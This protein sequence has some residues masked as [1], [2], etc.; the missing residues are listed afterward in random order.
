MNVGIALLPLLFLAFLIVGIL[1]GLVLLM[2][3]PKARVVT[4]TLLGSL[5]LIAM[6]L[7]AGLFFFRFY[8]TAVQRSATVAQ[9]APTI[10]HQIGT[11]SFAIST[12]KSEEEI[13]QEM[14]AKAAG[15]VQA[16]VRAV[17][18][19]LTEAEPVQA[20]EKDTAESLPSPAGRGTGGEGGKDAKDA[21]QPALTL[22][23]S[24]RE[25]GPARATLSQ[26]ERGPATDRPAWIDAPPQVV[27]DAYQMSISV[28]PY[29]TRVECNE[30]L[31]EALQ[32]ALDQYAEVCLGDQTVDRVRLPVE[33]LRKEIVKE[34]WEETRQHSVGPMVWLHVLLKF[35][36]KLKDQ[37]LEAYGRATVNRR[38]QLVGAWA[39][40]GLGLLTV[41]F[42]YLKIDMATG[43]AYRGRLRL[44]AVAVIL[45]VIAA[46]V[47]IAQKLRVVEM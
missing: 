2:A 42:G 34:Q 6:L 17:G 8:A 28:G 9:E 18:R 27:D 16:M 12:E 30:K 38:L 41:A 14:A 20:A 26:G 22:T 10:S 37:V 33:Y 24:Q 45:G 29:T 1:A 43:G 19:T 44:G 4:L 5:V 35:D 25:R 11:P 3:H 23:L 40:L 21:G 31:P 46:V 32:E 39:A 47:I 7:F 13:A 36:R 15:I